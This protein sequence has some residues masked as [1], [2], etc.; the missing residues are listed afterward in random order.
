MRRMRPLRFGLVLRLLGSPK[1]C[2][3]ATDSCRKQRGKAHFT[4]ALYYHFVSK[5]A[6]LAAVLEAQH[7]LAVTAFKIFGDRL[8]GSPEA[9]IDAMFQ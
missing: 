5:D 7:N 2:R 8:D 1:R 3:S 6:L 4:P 9:I